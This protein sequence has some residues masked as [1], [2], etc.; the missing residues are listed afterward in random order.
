MLSLQCECPA[1]AGRVYY[2]RDLGDSGKIED[3]FPTSLPT[4]NLGKTKGP[5]LSTESGQGVRLW[6]A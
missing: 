4:G 1:D 2:N 6:V 5:S 3:F